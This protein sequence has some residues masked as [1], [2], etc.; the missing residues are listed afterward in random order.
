MMNTKQVISATYGLGSLVAVLCS[1]IVNK[2]VFWAI[3]HF[4]FGWFYVVWA[5]V[6]HFGKIQGW[7]ERVGG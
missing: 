3:I 6:V 5:L 4:F 1:I 2:S 7:I